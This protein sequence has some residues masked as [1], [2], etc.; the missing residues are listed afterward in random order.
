VE[1]FFMGDL[2]NEKQYYTYVL[3]SRDYDKIY[4]GYTS[5]LERRLYFHNQGIKGW[6]AKFTP[7]ESIYHETFKD[8]SSAMK[9]E[10]QLKSYQGRKFI[11]DKVLP[12]YLESDK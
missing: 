5:D 6:T 8:K 12:D 10:K 11:K 3:Y 1:P 9:R 2:M 7:W 4:I